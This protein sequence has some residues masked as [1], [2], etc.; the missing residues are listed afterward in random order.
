M[1]ELHA[2]G[3]KT[4]RLVEELNIQLDANL[5]VHL[6]IGSKMR[7]SVLRAIATAS[8]LIFVCESAGATATKK[9]SFGGLASFY[10]ERGKVATGGRYV[11]TAFTAAH[12]TLPFGTKLRITDPTSG[13]SVHV[14]VNDRGPFKR[15]RILDLSLAAARALR[16][17]DRGVI[18]VRAT[19][20]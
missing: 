19:V 3:M 5:R 7:M 4:K 20:E 2:V 1:A 16:M 13:R 15:D 18:K 9:K 11:P 8:V 12:R 6:R 10:N 14:T 17:T